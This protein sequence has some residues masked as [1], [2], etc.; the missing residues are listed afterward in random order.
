VA[1]TF[2][3]LQFSGYQAA[4]FY[5]NLQFSVGAI[6]RPLLQRLDNLLDGDPI[7]LPIPEEAPPEIPRIFLTNKDRSLRFDLS[8]ARADFRWQRPDH[9]EMPL[10]RFTELAQYAF[11]GF[12]EAAQATPG[13]LALVVHRFKADDRPGFALAEH[14]CRPEL[15]A[16]EPRK[17]PLSRPEAFELHAFKRYHAG[18]FALNSW[19]RAKS[20]TLTN[21]Q[22]TQPIILVNKI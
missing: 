20:G 17:G 21:P 11:A 22:G 3:D 12:Q 8:P 4:A 7:S 6:V 9:G 16:N 2:R 19:V 1:I 5:V 15:L 13:R 18:R 10:G 14:F